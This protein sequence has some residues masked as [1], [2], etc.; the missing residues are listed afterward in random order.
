MS[1]EHSVAVGAIDAAPSDV[2]VVGDLLERNAREAPDEVF[3]TFDGGIQWTRREGLAVAYSVANALR[4][5]GIGRGDRIG[6]FLPNGP[7]LPAVWWGAA[8]I[9]AVMVPLN[10]A[11]R[12]A[13]LANAIKLSDPMVLVVDGGLSSRLDELDSTDFLPRRVS[14]ADLKGART[15]PRGGFPVVNPWDD[16]VMATT[17]GTTGP[18]KIARISYLH[19]HAGWGAALASQG[20]GAGDVFQVDLPLFHIAAIGAAYACLMTRARMRV[21]SRPAMNRYWEAV[22]E[23]GITCGSLLGTISALLLSNTPSPAEQDHAMRFLIGTPVPVNVRAFKARFRVPNI[24]G[25]YGAT[26]S[27]MVAFT[28]CDPELPPGFCGR[29]RAGFELLLVDANDQEVP[30]GTVGEALVRARRPFMMTSGYFRNAEAS[31]RA[32]RHGWFHTGDLLRADKDGNLYF[33][34]RSGDALRRRGENIS[35]LEVESGVATHPAVAEASCVAVASE[36][37]IEHDLKVWVVARPGAKIDFKELLT[38]CVQQLPHFMV[39]RYF[40]LIDELPKTP[41]AKV[42][43]YLLRQRGN[44]P[45]TWDSKLHGLIVTRRGLETVASDAQP[46]EPLLGNP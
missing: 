11:F 10:T 16:Q 15:R 5:M 41:S 8:I 17:S 35:A 26:E 1:I 28:D 23:D 18:P 32:W 33:V 40:E 12:G 14:P 29:V 44:T 19:L 38:H 42:Q 30:V 13:V 34:D 21:R 31:E 9:G 3:A 25:A 45:S 27:S 7:D 24:I 46:G 6:V 39:P 36:T 4:D 43:K 37:G 20:C 22:K 2:I